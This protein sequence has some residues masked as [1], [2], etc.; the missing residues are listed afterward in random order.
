MTRPLA[1]V[2]RDRLSILNHFASLVNSEGAS[3]GHRDS[4]TA[5]LGAKSSAHSYFNRLRIN[6]ADDMRNARLVSNAGVTEFD[7]ENF[8]VSGST[9][10]E[11]LSILR[12]RL[13]VQGA[14][15]YGIVV[16]TTGENDLIHSY[17][18][19][20]PE[21]CAMYGATLETSHAVDRFVSSAA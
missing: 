17:G 10:Q 4:V 8:A 5:G 3:V 7:I 1:Q 13:Q 9:S 12:D 11:H 18:R 21:E 14:D 20:P 16:M 19:R 6:P 15:V 2:L